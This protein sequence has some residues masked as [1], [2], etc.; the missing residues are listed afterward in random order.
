MSER[1]TA[2][3]VGNRRLLLTV[4]VIAL[5]WTALPSLSMRAAPL[6]TTIAIEDMTWTD[7][8]DARANGYFAIR[9]HHYRDSDSTNHL[10]PTILRTKQTKVTISH[11]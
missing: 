1:R 11:S 3:S 2:L 7:V 6:P 9:P 10:V 4:A 5:A 8:R